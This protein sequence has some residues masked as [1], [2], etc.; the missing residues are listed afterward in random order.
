VDVTERMKL[1]G[2]TA[3]PKPRGEGLAAK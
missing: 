1:E 2:E 3:R